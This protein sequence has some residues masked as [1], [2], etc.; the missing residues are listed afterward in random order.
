VFGLG[1]WLFVLDKAGYDHH[2]LTR[3]TVT[4]IRSPHPMAF[5]SCFCVPDVIVFGFILS[6]PEPQAPEPGSG[7]DTVK[8]ATDGNGGQS[9][10]GADWF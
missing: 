6:S 1:N 3:A 7:R 5:H 2:T 10:L 9:C 4:Q 8:A